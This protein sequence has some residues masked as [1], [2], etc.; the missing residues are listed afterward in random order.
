M[1][2]D[3]SVYRFIGGEPIPREQAWTMFLRQIGLWYHLG[4]GFWAIERKDTGAFVGECGFQERLRAMQP[5]IEGTIESGWALLG[6]VQGQGIGAE[7]MRTALAWAD[8]NAGIAMFTAIIDPDNVASV[9]LALKLGFAKR[10]PAD[11]S[12]HPVTIFERP[13]RG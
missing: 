5:P 12:G 10:G 7:A 13:R 11:Y 6:S 8:A 1:W 9:R 3:P 2:S 4:F